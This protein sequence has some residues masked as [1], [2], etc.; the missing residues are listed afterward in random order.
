[1][2]S[3]KK[4][5]Q[6]A[7]CSSCVLVFAVEEEGA[8]ARVAS[9]WDRLVRGGPRIH[10]SEYFHEGGIDELA[11][12]VSPHSHVPPTR[13]GSLPPGSARA[14]LQCISPRSGGPGVPPPSACAG[15]HAAAHLQQVQVRSGVWRQRGADSAESLAAVSSQ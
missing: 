2:L 5:Q 7:W 1:M 15:A 12:R 14:A 9:G 8:R 4:E 3:C 10:P 13:R 6:V 11:A